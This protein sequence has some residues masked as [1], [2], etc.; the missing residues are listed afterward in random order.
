MI[1][2]KKHI[3]SCGEELVEAAAQSYKS[4][5]LTVGRHLARA[6]PGIPGDICKSLRISS[7]QFRAD[8]TPATVLKIEHAVDSDL[9]LWAD[10]VE[11]HL[12]SKAAEAREI[13]LIMAGAAQSLTSRDRR[14]ADRFREITT[15]LQGI[16][17]LDDISQVRDALMASALELNT[18]VT[19]MESEGQQTITSLEVKL[20]EY[21]QQLAEAERREC[22]DTLT[23]LVN[24]RGI[25]ME[26]ERCRQERRLFCIVLMDLD[27]FKP[28]ND[29]YG[30]A[31]GD[32]LL[33][34]FAGELGAHFRSSDVIGRWGGDEFIVV[35]HGDEESVRTCVDRLRKWA[36]GTYKI[37]TA[38][39]VVAV[40]LTASVGIA[41][42][43]MEEGMLQVLGRADE[44]MYA[45]KRTGAKGLSKRA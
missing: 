41:R 45:E 27:S 42:W 4:L 22:A 31:A 6:V 3:D 9:S 28:V 34:Q 17:D 23:G 1:S 21:R 16:A 24:R 11:N 39:G 10:N 18:D 26:I 8:A 32:D 40:P 43:N 35:V 25:E 14:Y 33:R 37:K 44:S 7:E 19:N 12:K 30:H 2:L 5:L 20:Q 36:F 13:M 38:K 29:T 15:S